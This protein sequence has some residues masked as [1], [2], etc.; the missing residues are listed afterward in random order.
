VLTGVIDGTDESELPLAEVVVKAE[1]EL[2]AVEL[3]DIGS[4][5]DIVDDV[6]A[7]GS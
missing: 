6:L 4:E 7:L 2:D 5:N 3:T 1:I